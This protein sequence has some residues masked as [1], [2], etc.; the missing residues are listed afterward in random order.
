MA[1][2]YNG[3]GV[4]SSPFNADYAFSKQPCMAIQGSV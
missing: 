1:P 2:G 3:S 4:R